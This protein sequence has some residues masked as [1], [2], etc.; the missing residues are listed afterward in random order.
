M[1]AQTP[2]PWLLKSEPD[3]TS[4]QVWLAVSVNEWGELEER[5]VIADSSEQ[6]CAGIEMLR[7]RPIAALNE[8]MIDQAIARGEDGTILIRVRDTL[9]KLRERAAA[10]GQPLTDGTFPITWSAVTPWRRTACQEDGRNWKRRL[11]IFIQCGCKDVRSRN[12]I[13]APSSPAPACTTTECPPP[14]FPEP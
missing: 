12:W 9:I 11:T 2:A 1:N 7:E 3:L 13:K 10:T 8:T 14:R 6:V 4:D 5:L